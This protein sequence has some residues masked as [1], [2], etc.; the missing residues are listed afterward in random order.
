MTIL[1]VI[2]LVIVIRAWGI[3]EREDREYIKRL[4]KEITRLRKEVA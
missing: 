3:Q 2:V 4:E 1:L